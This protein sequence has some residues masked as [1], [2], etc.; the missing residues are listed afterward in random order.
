VSLIAPKHK[1]LGVLKEH[2]PIVGDY[3]LKAIKEVLKEHATDEI[4]S[5]WGTYY[6]VLAK[7]FIDA[8]EELYQQSEKME[9]GWRYKKEFVI[10]RKVKESTNITSFYLKPSEGGPVPVFSG[11]QYIVVSLLVPSDQYINNRQYSL[12]DMPNNEYYRISVKRENDN[13]DHN[14][15]ISNH[16]HDNLK[17]GDKIDLHTPSGDFTYKPTD[18]KIV[19]LAGGVGLNP[20]M[21][22]LKQLSVTDKE[23]HIT[24]VHSVRQGDLYFYDEVMQLKTQMPN[25]EY[26]VVCSQNIEHVNHVGRVNEKWITDNLEMESSYYICGPITYMRDVIGI[27]K[28]KGATDINYEFF[29]PSVNF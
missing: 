12:T 23:H 21:S 27:L 13:K 3:L 15:T 6:G 5:A 4:I 16:L 28:A 17:E 25:L 2:Y 22:M 20:M 7:I 18:K 26:V 10:E 19:F 8:E 1:S 11:G 14:G 9:G 24:L 29:G